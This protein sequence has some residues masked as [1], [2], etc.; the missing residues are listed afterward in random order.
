MPSWIIPFLELESTTIPPPSRNTTR[1]GYT[2]N[3]LIEAGNILYT[4]SCCSTSRNWESRGALYFA[5][6]GLHACGRWPAPLLV[7]TDSG[8]SLRW[9]DYP[10]CLD[11]SCSTRCIGDISNRTFR[12]GLFSLYAWDGKTIWMWR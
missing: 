10:A 8:P 5:G 9:E 4:T 3:R 6:C 12:S 2:R 11:S 1:P 7:E